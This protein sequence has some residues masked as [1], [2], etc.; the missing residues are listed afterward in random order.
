MP[1]LSSSGKLTFSV[2]KE[3]NL[4]GMCEGHAAPEDLCKQA[5]DPHKGCS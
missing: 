3:Y 1:S 5:A 2:G 4:R